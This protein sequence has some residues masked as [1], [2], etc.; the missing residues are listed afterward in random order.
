MTDLIGDK[1]VCKV[2]P[3]TLGLLKTHHIFQMP[4]GQQ[5]IYEG[6]CVNYQQQFIEKTYI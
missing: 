2:A 6:F 3:A 1:G 4:S 5:P